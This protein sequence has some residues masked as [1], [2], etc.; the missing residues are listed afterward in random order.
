MS[1]RI[2]KRE[3]INRILSY[4]HEEDKPYL[5]NELALLDK[6]NSTERKPSEK[7]IAKQNADAELRTAIVAEMEQNR[8]YSAI[9]I[10]ALPTPCASQITPAKVHYLMRDSITNGV[11][12]K[13][14]EKRHTFYS[15][16]G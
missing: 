16:A 9:E 1:K 11:V 15:L 7:D 13:S 14:V 12:V 5:M 2:T 6:K 4:A 8:L 10:C 3:Y